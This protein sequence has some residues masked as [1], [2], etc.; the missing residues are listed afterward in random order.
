MAGALTHSPARVLAKLLADAG[1]GSDPDAATLGS[2]PVYWSKEP[3]APDE[4]VT[5]RDS[6]PRQHARDGWPGGLLQDEGLVLR[7]RA[8]THEAGDRKIRAVLAFLNDSVTH[9]H[10]PIG[11]SQYDVWTVD[12]QS[13]PVHIGEDAPASHRHVFVANLL[14]TLVQLT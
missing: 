4:C 14:V 6:A 3:D 13:G 5:V 11:S 10:V 12:R 9:R 7:V 2:W 8:R 1:Q